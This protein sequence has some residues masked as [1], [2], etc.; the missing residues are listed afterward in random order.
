MK[1]KR[2]Q[3]HQESKFDSGF[4]AGRTK[5]DPESNSESRLDAVAVWQ[6]VKIRTSLR[7]STNI[8]KNASKST[9][10]N[11]NQEE[12]MRINEKQRNPESNFDPGY[13]AG[14]TKGDLESTFDFG[15]DALR[16]EVTVW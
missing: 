7:N 4:A 5:R 6:S 9:R 15:F 16:V 11:N 2:K 10:S 12:S 1:I 13:A 3:R 8:K 14:R